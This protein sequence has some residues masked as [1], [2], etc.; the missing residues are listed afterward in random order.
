MRIFPIILILLITNL[1][2]AQYLHTPKQIES[3]MEES[4]LTYSQ[5]HF[6]PE[7]TAKSPYVL[8]FPFETLISADTSP[9]DVKTTKLSNREQ[10]QLR[11]ANQFYKD[12]KYEAAISQYQKSEFLSRVPKVKARIAFC[13]DKMDQPQD[14]IQIYSELLA[15]DSS[16]A[17]LHFQLANCYFQQEEFKLAVREITMA[18]LYNR[19]K[20]SYL[21]IL[22]QFYLRQ[23]Q[24]F[25][26]L[27]F[28]P[29]YNLLRTKEEVKIVAS[30]LPWMSYA[31]A[32]AV[33]AHEPDY[34]EKMNFISSEDS[35]I[36][37]EKECLL[38][39]LIAYEGLEAPEK[40]N[41]PGLYTLSSALPDKRVNDFI[42]YEIS[43]AAQP[44]IA[45]QLSTDR[46]EQLMDYIFTYRVKVDE[47][48]Q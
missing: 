9:I 43:L 1:L 4:P 46:I 44:E 38:N 20:K 8:I 25:R 24:K 37:E 18:H 16:N 33:W 47:V 48:A 14:A 31:S 34:R 28:E 29:K 19:N 17:F 21:D 36:I 22:A 2:T 15:T 42:M 26:P 41:Y 13:Y 45:T 32:K 5:Y 30:S 27:D 10:K 7:I 3:I 11:K 39:A 40:I 12:Q 35:R 6:E 23:N